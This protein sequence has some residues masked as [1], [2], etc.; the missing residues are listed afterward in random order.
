MAHVI[1]TRHDLHRQTDAWPFRSPLPFAKRED[2]DEGLAR[3]TPVRLGQN[4][5][6]IKRLSLNRN[7]GRNFHCGKE[8]QSRLGRVRKSR[9]DESRRKIEIPQR[10]EIFV[11]KEKSRSENWPDEVESSRL[12]SHGRTNSDTGL[13]HLRAPT[14]IR[15][16]GRRKFGLA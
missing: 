11:A 15:S 13:L 7:S 12:R 1:I 3:Q 4:R 14:P 5:L 2:Q 16:P 10:K 6:S 8:E 9:Q